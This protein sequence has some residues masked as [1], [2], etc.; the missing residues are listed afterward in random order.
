MLTP[1]SA[2]CDVLAATMFTAQLYYFSRTLYAYVCTCILVHNYSSRCASFS[3][4]AHQTHS[5][6][7]FLPPSLS[8]SL[9]P[10]IHPS[11]PPSVP[12]S[13][14]PSLPPPSLSPSHAA[15]FLVLGGYSSLQWYIRRREEMVRA[16]FI[17][18]DR[19]MGQCCSGG[20]ELAGE[21]QAAALRTCTI[22][23]H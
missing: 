12:L 6:P 18:V 15:L 9:K 7:P 11:L 17:M 22:A 23:F 8:S 20:S 21:G 19:I 16:T 1:L 3:V 4:C 5:C 2:V 10:F 13:L 14:P